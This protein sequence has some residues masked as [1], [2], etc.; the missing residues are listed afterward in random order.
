MI[1]EGIWYVIKLNEIQD[2]TVSW[3][4]CVGRFVK[5]VFAKTVNCF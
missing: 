4:C 3:I 5:V 1:A 2:N